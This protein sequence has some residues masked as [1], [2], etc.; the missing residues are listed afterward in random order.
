MYFL[1]K[2]GHFCSQGDARRRA[3]RATREDDVVNRPK[4][5]RFRN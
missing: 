1:R 3:A 2:A 4:T 5:R